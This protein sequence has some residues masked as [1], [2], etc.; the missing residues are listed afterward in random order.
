MPPKVKCLLELVSGADQLFSQIW[1]IG[2]RSNATAHPSSDWDLLVFGCFGTPEILRN[3]VAIDR[4]KFDALVVYNGNDFMDPWDCKRG[5]LSS[6][7]WEQTSEVDAVYVGTK[8]DERTD[9]VVS[10]KL[11]ARRLCPFDDVQRT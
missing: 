6:W 10:R 11:K 8:S 3:N 1:L 4:S 5:S 2:S 9:R 7:G